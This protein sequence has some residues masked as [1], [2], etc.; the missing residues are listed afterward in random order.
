LRL[1]QA[2]LADPGFAHTEIVV[3]T[4]EAAFVGEAAPGRGLACAP[5]WGLVRAARN[6]HLERRFRVVDIDPQIETSTLERLLVTALVNE[7]PELVV[8]KERATAV[9]LVR[10]LPGEREE[11]VLDPQGTVLI[12]GG[13]GELGQ[14]LAQHL[15]SAHGA[16]HLVLTSRR[17]AVAPGTAVLLSNLEAAGAERVQVLACDV[18]DR[19]DVE[20]VLGSVD[21]AH[22]LTSVFHLAGVLD[23]GLLANQDDARLQAIADSIR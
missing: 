22:P 16:R 17:G 14:A 21:P 2:V 23:D 6:E 19:A 15:V 10:A 7:E 4:C 12:T 1:L 5:L 9:R 13:T 11:P 3:V 20:R 18:A 8:R